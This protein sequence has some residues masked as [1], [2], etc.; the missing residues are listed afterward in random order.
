MDFEFTTALIPEAT[1]ILIKGMGGIFIV[2]F[3]I[4]LSCVALQRFF[5]EGEA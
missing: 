4:Y 2:L 3:I 5:P 1:G